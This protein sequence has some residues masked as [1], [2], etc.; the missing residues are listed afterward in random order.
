MNVTNLLRG[1]A[2]I[3]ANFGFLKGS[4]MSRVAAP[5][6]PKVRRGLQH[7]TSQ[8]PKEVRLM[9]RWVE[10]QSD[11]AQALFFNPQMQSRFRLIS[12]QT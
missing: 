8:S 5:V 3:Y 7:S 12:K 10:E 1:G 2:D 4:G 6:V 11:N 9:R